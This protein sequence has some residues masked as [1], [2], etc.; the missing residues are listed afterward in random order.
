VL[1]E[2]AARPAHLVTGGPG[3]DLVRAR[4]EH[5]A[6][7]VAGESVADV[8]DVEVGGVG[9]R[10]LRPRCPHP[11]VLVYLHGGGW[12]FGSP[13]E[14]EPLCRALVNRSD[15][16]VLL[17]DYRLAPEHPFPAAIED[18]EAVVAALPQCATG[19]GVDASMLAI[20]GDSA[21]ANLGVAVTLRA[22]D[23]GVQPFAYQALIYPV[24]D[25]VSQAPSVTEFG[26]GYGLDH[27]AIRWHADSYV[28]DPADRERP[29][30]SPLRARSL[31][32]LPPTLVVTAEFD[33]LR[34][35]GEA[36]ATRLAEAGVPV[37]ATR[38]LGVL[39]GFADP[40]VFDAAHAVLDQVAGALRRTKG[41]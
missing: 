23:Q 7:A 28:P 20:A 29:E 5:R 19:L 32:D 12:T 24:V 34:D 40:A 17:V 35:E 11:P 38:Y 16:A 37:V 21:G 18:V 6:R 36:F 25:L 14:A 15:W 3:F 27:A 33:P 39:H 4:A 8:T 9:C 2:V 13:E 10:L 1:V 22:R 30:V 26:T 41:R 31:A